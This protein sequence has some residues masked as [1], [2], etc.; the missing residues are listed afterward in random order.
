MT[1]MLGSKRAQISKEGGC[2]P[3][4]GRKERWLQ[5]LQR[6][7]RRCQRRSN[8]SHR[9]AMA[10]TSVSD[11]V[12]PMEIHPPKDQEEPME[13]SP[14]PAWLPWH[15]YTMPRLPSMM[16]QQHLTVCPASVSTISWEAQP[17]R[18]AILWTHL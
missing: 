16:P 8:I 15:H 3:L 7:K 1:R 17:L 11:G 10:I 12:E 2:Q 13:V 18:L 6:K 4:N 5:K 14:P 9:L